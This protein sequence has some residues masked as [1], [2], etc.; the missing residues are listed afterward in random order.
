MAITKENLQ[1]IGIIAFGAFFLIF[2]TVLYRLNYIKIDRLPIYY[3]LS[4]VLVVIGIIILLLSRKM[5]QPL[6]RNKKRDK[7]RN[8]AT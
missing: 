3:G 4:S 8:R 1:G 6:P 5:T 2:V 7:K